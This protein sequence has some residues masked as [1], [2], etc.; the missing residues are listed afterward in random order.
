MLSNI[1]LLKL[2]EVD[3]KLRQFLNNAI[4]SFLQYPIGASS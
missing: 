4:L 3:I 1:L 2:T